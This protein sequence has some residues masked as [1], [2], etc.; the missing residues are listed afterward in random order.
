[1]AKFFQDHIWQESIFAI[2]LSC[3]ISDF[4]LFYR[5]LIEK[6]PQNSAETRRRNAN[7]IVQRFF[8][9]KTL[10]QPTRQAW[11][12]YKDENLLQ[13]LMRYQFLMSEPV[14][15]NFAKL[16]V[17]RRE[18]GECLDFGKL[19]DSFIEQTYGE[20]KPKLRDNLSGALQATGLVTRVKRSMYVREL[21]DLER[22]FGILLH[23]L[24]APNPT[25]IAVKDIL[26]HT[27][28]QY[29]GLRSP[30]NVVKLLRW[31]EARKIILKYVR[32][33]QLEQVTTAYSAE[34]ILHNKRLL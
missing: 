27:F 16:Q 9:E 33:D 34:E 24:F 30:S 17:F 26:S 25:T 28:W 12:I 32:V 1:M 23:V 18:P 15:A 8:P 14:I 4:D 6:L 13:H 20:V 31:L 19:A 11:Q 22:A 2:K 29:L 10:N 3:R 7:I 21:S 5:Q